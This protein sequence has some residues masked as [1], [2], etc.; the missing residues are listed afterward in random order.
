MNQVRRKKGI[1]GKRD[2]RWF[3]YMLPIM[4]IMV[5]AFALI[6]KIQLQLS[7]TTADLGIWII[8][9][10]ISAASICGFGYAGLKTA[11]TTSVAGV[12]A[13]I[14]FMS[15]VFS[16]QIEAKGLVGLIS[17]AEL[18]F[19]FVIVGINLQMLQYLMKKRRREA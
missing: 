19:I 15:Y 7:I 18:A 11:M 5:I 13:G 4:V 2:K 8:L 10:F 16:Q 14:I 12:L 6:S 9:S 3:L 17:G 1:P